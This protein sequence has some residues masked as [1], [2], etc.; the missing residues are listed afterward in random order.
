MV[1]KGLVSAPGQGGD[2]RSSEKS[3]LDSYSTKAAS[4]MGVSKRTVEKDIARGEKIA[5]AVMAEVVGTALDKGVVLDRLAAAPISKQ[6]GVLA[7]IRQE[8]SRVPLASPPARSSRLSRQPDGP[9]AWRW[10]S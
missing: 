3:S 8:R 2:R 6:A 1:R 10:R 5:P 4:D 9:C 7:D